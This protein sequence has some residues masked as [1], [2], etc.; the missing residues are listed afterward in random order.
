MEVAQLLAFQKQLVSSDLSSVG[1][2]CYF[3]GEKTLD[4]VLRGRW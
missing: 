4:P 2:V 1:G 3:L